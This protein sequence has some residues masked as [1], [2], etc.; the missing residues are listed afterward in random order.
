MPQSLLLLLGLLLLSVP[1]KPEPQMLLAQD[2][3]RTPS[4]H[5]RRAELVFSK[6]AGRPQ[7]QQGQTGTC[8]VCC[9]PKIVIPDSTCQ[10]L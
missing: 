9:Q 4:R 7:Q 5:H 2:A 10:Q 3:T 6:Q 1:S 8:L